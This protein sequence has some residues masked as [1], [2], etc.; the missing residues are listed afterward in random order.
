VVVWTTRQPALAQDLSLND[1]AGASQPIAL[2]LSNK[3]LNIIDLDGGNTVPSAFHGHGYLRWVS[4]AGESAPMDTF[5]FSVV[6]RNGSRFL[7][8][9][10]FQ[11]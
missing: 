10:D 8:Q 7:L 6:T 1:G 9:G 4:P 3:H 5:L 11:D 2:P